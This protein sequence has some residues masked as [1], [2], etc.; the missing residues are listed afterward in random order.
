MK[1]FPWSAVLLLA[2]IFLFA[3]LFTHCTT[4]KKEEKSDLPPGEGPPPIY[5]PN[6]Y[7]W[8]L[9]DT[10]YE[11]EFGEWHHLEAPSIDLPIKGAYFPTHGFGYVFSD[12]R[13]YQYNGG[14]WK[15]FT[16]TDKPPAFFF[17]MAMTG[18]GAMWFASIDLF[19]NSYLT[20]LSLDGLTT[21]YSV[22]EAITTSRARVTSIL[23]IPGDPFLQILAEV[24]GWWQRLYFDGAAWVGDEIVES[25]LGA[26]TVVYDL[27]LA[28]DGTYWA[29]GQDQNAGEPRGV[30]WHGEG[31]GWTRIVGEMVSDCRTYNVRRLYFTPD[32]FGYALADCLWTQI[33][34]SEDLQNWIEMYL[35]GDKGEAFFISDLSM[36]SDSEGWAVGYNSIM[37]E[38]LLLVRDIN[39]WQQARPRETGLGDILYATVMFPYPHN[40]GPDDDT[41]TDDDTMPADDD[42]APTD[43]DTTPTDDDTTP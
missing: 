30:F 12:R 10:V 21:V 22:Q 28:P 27:N 40:L 39:G 5:D 33:Y 15:D 19:Q 20:S 38:P 31:G 37:D 3:S 36:V 18:D 42:T 17:D 9:G 8:G 6:I 13:I 41:V 25:P 11:Y 23:S 26:S 24:D 2:L 16:P 34:R 4:K 29:V 32:G 35:P 7:G 14:I 43:D 1:R